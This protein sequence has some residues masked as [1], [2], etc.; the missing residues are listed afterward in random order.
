MRSSLSRKMPAS[1]RASAHP[2]AACRVRQSRWLHR[3]HPLPRRRHRH[4]HAPPSPQ[5][6]THGV[7]CRAR[8]RPRC[9]SFIAGARTLK[10]V[11][12]VGDVDLERTLPL[13]CPSTSTSRRGDLATREC[14][15]VDARKLEPHSTSSPTP[16][17]HVGVRRLEA[18][19]SDPRYAAGGRGVLERRLCPSAPLSFCQYT[20]AP[21]YAADTRRKR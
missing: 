18:G 21:G 11:L 2:A 19:F 3:A 17:L 8:P 12:A 10:L 13:R 16:D 9:Q 1:H 6:H 20:L 4:R 14:G 5:T 7:A 15:V